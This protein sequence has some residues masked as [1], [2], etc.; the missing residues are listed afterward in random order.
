MAGGHSEDGI[1]D[2]AA[3]RMEAAGAW[4]CKTTRLTPGRSGIPDLL[5]CYL[6][7]FGAFEFKRPVKPAPFT[8]AQKRELAAIEKA[9]GVA[10]KVTSVEECIDT[11]REI[12]ARVT[13]VTD[14]APT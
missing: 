12:R 4:V 1:R 7:V 9:G 14:G 11:L 6:G 13:A 5:F 10:K 2:N 8:P 3:R